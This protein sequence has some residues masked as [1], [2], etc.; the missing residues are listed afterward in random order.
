M[1][2]ETDGHLGQDTQ[3]WEGVG[4]ECEDLGRLSR[5]RKRGQEGA[6][7][8]YSQVNKKKISGMKK[9]RWRE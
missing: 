6:R 9:G 2:H 8:T 5:I 1:E 3:E 4:M 7:A